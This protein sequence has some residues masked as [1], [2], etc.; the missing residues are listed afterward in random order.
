MNSVVTEYS[1]ET[2]I[3][4]I[5][6]GE[7]GLFEL[8]I[9]RHNALLYKIGRSYG[10]AHEDAKDLLQETHIAA[11]RSLDKFESRSSYKTWIARIMVNKCLY[12]MK[13]GSFKY[14]VRKESIDENASPLFSAK[15]PRSDAVVNKE[16]ATILE[17]S[18]ENIPVNY[19]TVFILREVEGLSIAETSALLDLT[20]VNVKVRLSRAKAMLQQELEKHYSKAQ[21]YDFNLVYCDDVVNNVMNAIK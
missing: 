1:E 9:R 5:L 10:F 16:L 20:E 21:L 8:L 13:Y 12:K 19:R 18:L 6:E 11:Y 7:T 2:I 17:K 3:Q 14:E 15:N 4:K